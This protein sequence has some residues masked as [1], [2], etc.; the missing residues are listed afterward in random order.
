MNKLSKTFLVTALTISIASCSYYDRQVIIDPLPNHSEME[1]PVSSDYNIIALDGRDNKKI[2]AIGN[3]VL[4]KEVVEISS[5]QNIPAIIKEELIKGF[6][7][8]DI[9]F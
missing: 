9:T 2:L 6:A 5:T 7:R 8:Q 1:E 4:G 3:K